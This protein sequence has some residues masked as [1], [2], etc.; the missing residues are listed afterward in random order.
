MLLPPSDTTTPRKPKER[1]VSSILL[2]AQ[3]AIAV[4]PLEPVENAC[5]VIDMGTFVGVGGSSDRVAL[6]VLGN[7]YGAG[8]DQA[9]R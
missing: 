6:L 4:S 8:L 3:R 7:T 9:Q 2:Q 5:R 1:E